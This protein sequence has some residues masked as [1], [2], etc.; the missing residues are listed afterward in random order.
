MFGENKR[1][2]LF[3]CEDCQMI[4]S[5]ELEDPVDIASIEDNTMELECPCEGKC[6]VLKD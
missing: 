6:L 1:N 5:V 4:T 3:R 2:F